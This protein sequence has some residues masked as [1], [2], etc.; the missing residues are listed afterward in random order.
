MRLLIRNAEGSPMSVAVESH[1]VRGRIRTASFVETV[2]DARQV[3][4]NLPQ[5]SPRN[6][7]ALYAA[8]DVALDVLAGQKQARP[9]DEQSLVILTDGRDD[10]RPGDDP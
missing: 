9:R 6:N 7:T 5:P 2:A 1:D 3:I 10:V 4:A 8:V